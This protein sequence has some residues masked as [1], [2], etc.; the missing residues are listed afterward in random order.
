M[1]RP[2]FTFFKDAI[3][4]FQHDA[5]LLVWMAMLLDNAVRLKLGQGKHEPFGRAGAHRHAGEDAVQ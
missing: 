3:D 4:A 1:R 2:D 5:D